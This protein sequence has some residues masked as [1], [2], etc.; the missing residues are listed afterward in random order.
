MSELTDRLREIADP[1]FPGVMGYSAANVLR[2]AA[3]RIEELEGHVL[4]GDLESQVTDIWGSTQFDWTVGRSG[5]GWFY[6]C[7]SMRTPGDRPD[8]KHGGHE[9]TLIEALLRMIAL[10]DEPSNRLSPEARAVLAEQ[11]ETL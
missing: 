8:W 9:E 10:R 5:D 3:D 1:N 4:E 6:Y 7:G 2:A 11:E